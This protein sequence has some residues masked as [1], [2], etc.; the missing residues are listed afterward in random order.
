M[1]KTKIYAVREGH[2]PGIYFSW[3]DCKSQVDG[4][5]GAKYKSFSG[6]KAL[7]EAYAFMQ[8]EQEEEK[9]VAEPVVEKKEVS[10]VEL[11]NGPYA[12][13]DGSFNPETN[14]YGYGGYLV[15]GNRKYP[16]MGSGKDPDMASMRNVSGE[17]SGAMAAVKKAETL[18]IRS[19]TILYDYKGIEEW[20]KGRW[21]ANK[22]GTSRY[23]DFMSSA[24]RSVSID[25][26]KVPAHTGVPGNEDADRMAKRAVGIKMSKADEARVDEILAGSAR[27]GLDISG[28]ETPDD[29]K[30]MIR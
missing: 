23:Q 3:A 4:Y 27:D 6:D 30:E 20:A 17:I 19:M 22:T 15:A 26:Q 8:P 11:P 21:Q 2:T 12:F 16:L 13:V 9:T 7:D 24:H 25:F 29:D 5:Q 28:I 14:T 10:E 18:G 1:A